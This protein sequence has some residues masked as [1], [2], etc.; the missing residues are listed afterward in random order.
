MKKS[1]TNSVYTSGGARVET[2]NARS[3]LFCF[4][5]ATVAKVRVPHQNAVVN[6][7]V[8]YSQCI[9]IVLKCIEFVPM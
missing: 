4:S 7:F 1:R 6:N 9:G 5:R 2:S 8:P 3:F